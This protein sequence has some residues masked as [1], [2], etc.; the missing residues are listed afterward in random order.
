MKTRA[1]SLFT[2]CILFIALNLS[3]RSASGQQAF[4]INFEAIRQSVVFLYFKDPT[5]KVQE[6][7]TGFLL[8]IAEKENPNQIY[9][10]LVTARHIADPKW[11]GCEEK[12]GEWF[13]RLNKRSFDP[14][15]DDIGTVEEAIGTPD[16]PVN[17]IY[18]DDDSVDIAFT[19]VNGQVF[20][21]LKADNK[22]LV[23]QLPTTEELKTINTGAQIT[24]A[25]LLLG[26]SGE[27][28]N[29]P[30]FKFGY[31]SSIPAETV[32][33]RGCGSFIRQASEWMIA[34]SLVPGNSGSPI[35]FV[36][37][38]FPGLQIG[39]QQPFLLGVQSSA[40]GGSDVAG[41]APVQY[42]IDKLRELNIPDADL[43][44]SPNTVAKPSSTQ[45]IPHIPNSVPM[46]H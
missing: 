14:I 8:A 5:G 11:L 13:A 36:P 45:P 16:H 20:E 24:S 39:N 17:W 28:R 33:I 4:N 41:M 34:A 26:A 31:V 7:G 1:K 6:A 10:L 35:F 19:P 37:T 42:L 32:P 40:F 29:Y 25:G 22:F 2:V 15:K 3:T 30:I 27:K 38:G 23:R 12:Q 9:E 18:P 44:S 21:S 46:P 43:P